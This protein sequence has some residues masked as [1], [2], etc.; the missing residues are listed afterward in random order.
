MII[1][2]FYTKNKIHKITANIYI[3]IQVATE[4]SVF[5]LKRFPNESAIVNVRKQKTLILN[6]L[7]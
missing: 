5:D 4:I 6:I 1:R 7:Y 3:A 2:K